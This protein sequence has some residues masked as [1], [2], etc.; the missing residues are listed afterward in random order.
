MR[1]IAAVLLLTLP[2]FSQSTARVETVAGRAPDFSPQPAAAARLYNPSRVLTYPG[3]NTYTFETNGRIRRIHPDNVV[4]PHAL[5]PSNDYAVD[6]QGTIYLLAGTGVTAISPE[7]AVSSL[8]SFPN[9]PSTSVV[10]RSPSAI[11]VSASGL[12]FIGAASGTYLLSRDGSAVTIAAR[13]TSPFRLLATPSGLLLIDNSRRRVFR[14]ENPIAGNGQFGEPQTGVPATESPFGTL[15][16]LATDSSG[17]LYLADAAFRTVYRLNPDSGSLEPFPPNRNKFPAVDFLTIDDQDHLLI[18][19]SASSAIWR[20]SPDGEILR[21]AGRDLTVPTLA[22]DVELDQPSGLALHPGGDLYF[23]DSNGTRIRKLDP[24]GNVSLIAGNGGTTSAGDGGPAL[25]AAFAA[26]G[27]LVIGSND[28]IYFVDQARAVRR[29]QPCGPIETWA[30]V[31]DLGITPPNGIGLI[32][33]A[34]DNGLYALWSNG[35]VLFSANR[36]AT[37][38]IRFDE[39]LPGLPFVSIDP[40]FLASTSSGDAILWTGRALLSYSPSSG[41]TQL[42]S[43]SD[44]DSNADRL[45]LGESL[46][47]QA[48]AY[49]QNIYIANSS[50]LCLR[51]PA[52]KL[53]R[54]AGNFSSRPP[55]ADGADPFSGA[56]AYLLRI[57]PAPNGVVYFSERDNNLIRRYLPF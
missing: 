32:A 9:H 36:T 3:G 8:H 21:F 31:A 16:S 30:T 23:Y 20:V 45:C 1:S 5:A 49:E 11:A 33:A 34:P 29:F 44:S 22:R 56:L 37:T 14:G 52:G 41:F 17:R 46:S 10:L 42:P 51:D 2:L 25:E 28:W 19:D 24:T 55:L 15:S 57:A 13:A 50:N 43:F 6:S 27:S 40:S 39:P 48:A 35:L 7:G 4:R 26:R 53:T 47:F 18:A 38:L 54:L 12:L